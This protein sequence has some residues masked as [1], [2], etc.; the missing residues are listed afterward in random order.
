MRQIEEHFNQNRPVL[1]DGAMGT[2]LQ[3]RG[4][5]L[6][7]PQWSAA[8]LESDPGVI[9][10]IHREYIDAGA[11]LNTTVTFRTTSRVYNEMGGAE[12]AKD[13]THRAV[14]CARDAIAGKDNIFIAGSVAPLEDCYRPDLVP[15]DRS[16]EQEHAE[17]IGWL[18]DAGADCLLFETQNTIREATICAEIADKSAFPF[19]VAFVCNTPET[20]IS[21]ESLVDAVNAVIPFEPLALLINCTHPDIVTDGLKSLRD[22]VEYPLGAYANLGEST[23]EQEGT[24]GDIINLEKYV[25]YVRQWIVLDNIALVGGCCGSTPRHIRAVYNLLD[26]VG[27]TLK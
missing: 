17:Q 19:L 1:L 27:T 12:Y 4:Y 10:D 15:D 24:L 18:I 13:L 5:D 11:T 6:P 20:L 8:L 7:S 3:A 14:R 9:T 21:G 16:L 23:P 26:E 25:D 2:L 22:S